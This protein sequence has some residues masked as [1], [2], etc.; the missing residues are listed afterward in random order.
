MPPPPIYLTLLGEQRQV[1]LRAKGG[2]PVL[3]NVSLLTD[4]LALIDYIGVERRFQ[5]AIKRP[6][7]QLKEQQEQAILALVVIVL[8]RTRLRYT[9]KIN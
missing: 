8:V 3:E 9:P 6:Q 5:P 2:N 1:L 4:V 7:K